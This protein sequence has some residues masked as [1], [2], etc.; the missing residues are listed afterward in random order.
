[1]KPALFH[2]TAPELQVNCEVIWIDLLPYIYT[3]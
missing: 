1:M 2:L 3:W